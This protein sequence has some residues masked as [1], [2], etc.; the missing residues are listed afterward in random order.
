MQ[1]GK[2]KI[3]KGQRNRLKYYHYFLIP[4]MVLITCLIV[5]PMVSIFFYSIIDQT[6]EFPIYS[7]TI[8]NYMDFFQKKEFLL[9]IGK[10]LYLSIVSTLLCLLISYPLAYFISRRRKSL[11]ATL[12]LLVT[13]PMWI[14]MLLRTLAI[15][16]VLDGPLLKLFKV[17]GYNGTTLLGNEL[18]IIF[19]MIYIY[20]PFMVLP[21]YTILSKIDYKLV[22]ASIDLG[23][24]KNQTFRKV[25]LPLSLPG[26][27]SGITIVFLSTATTIVISK[28]LGEGKYV[29]I[30]NIIENEFI[31][32]SRWSYG[33]AISVILLVII[34]GLMWLTSKV[35]KNVKDG[36][37]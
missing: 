14:N 32:N 9:A 5:L 27:L 15:K 3:A 29:L 4:F 33:S 6:S 20:L 19:G 23:A 34:M 18:A 30:G 24:S 21:I 35:E 7:L 36:D 2:L 8:N 37:N 10:S 17:L 16:Q 28:Y 31:T 25:I 12:I 26:I 1:V 22:E 13:S 11:Q